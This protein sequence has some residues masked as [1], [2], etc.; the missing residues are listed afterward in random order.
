MIAYLIAL[1][2]AIF[3]DNVFGIRI[4]AVV[5]SGA[6]QYLSLPARQKTF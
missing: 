4:M 1:G 5:S 3:G 2:T 6:E